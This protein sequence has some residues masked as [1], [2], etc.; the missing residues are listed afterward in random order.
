MD[1][2]SIIQPMESILPVKQVP[3][4]LIG[5]EE[6]VNE[7][8]TT[9]IDQKD[10]ESSV[11]HETNQSENVEQTVVIKPE[12][13]APRESEVEK[14]EDLSANDDNDQNESGTN[15][16]ETDPE[17]TE[18]DNNKVENVESGLVNTNTEGE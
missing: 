3:E 5:Q 18:A 12:E 14:S 6:E 16:Q 9:A 15:K 7:L 4:P 2:G 8:T 17:L 13:E 1:T 11:S 10:E